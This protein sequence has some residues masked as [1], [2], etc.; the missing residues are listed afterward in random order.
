MPGKQAKILSVDD[1]LDLLIFANCTRHAARNRVIVL[2]TAKAGLRA[3]EIA[4]LTWDMVLDPTGDIGSV[5]EL[6]DIAAKNGSGR[7]IPMHPDL[8]QA[9]TALQGLANGIGPV[10]R[11]ERGGAMTPLSIVLWFNRAFRNIGLNG[12]SSHSGRRRQLPMTKG[13]IYNAGFNRLANK[14]VF[15]IECSFLGL[16]RYFSLR[17]APARLQSLSNLNCNGND[18]Q[19]RQNIIS[20][21]C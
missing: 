7:L 9:L 15:F 11:S 20:R 10:I 16:I 17:T 12:C 6:H 14:F 2:L 13:K 18:W 3:G 5:I 4:Q 19:A 1:V 21:S 8:R